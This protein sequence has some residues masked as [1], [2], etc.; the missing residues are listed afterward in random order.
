MA[1]KKIELEVDFIGGQG[2]LTATEE[3][4]LSNFFKNRKMSSKQIPSPKRHRISKRR[5]ATA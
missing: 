2:S 4:V 3:K 5:K 1:T